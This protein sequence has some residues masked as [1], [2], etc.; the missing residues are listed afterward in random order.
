MSPWNSNIIIIFVCKIICHLAVT[1]CSEHN[2]LL[3][4][5][6]LCKNKH[7]YCSAPCS[8]VCEYE[9][10]V[11]FCLT[12]SRKSR[13]AGQSWLW[14]GACRFWRMLSYAFGENSEIKWVIRKCV[15]YRSSLKL[16]KMYRIWITWSVSSNICWYL[17]VKRIMLVPDRYIEVWKVACASQVFIICRKRCKVRI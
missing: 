7:Y 9:Q 2:F 12:R 15:I 8:H 6:H 13:H 1:S 17:R 10:F 16:V 11:I 14:K 5:S 3:H 4:C